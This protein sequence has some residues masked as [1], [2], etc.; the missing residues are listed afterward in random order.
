MCWEIGQLFQ[1]GK[2]LTLIKL[3]L[4][5]L[6]LIWGGKEDRW[7]QA[8]LEERWKIKGVSSCNPL[9]L[10]SKVIT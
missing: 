9:P 7:I 8:G 2:W 1:R 3:L 5:S 6:N 10:V 4:R